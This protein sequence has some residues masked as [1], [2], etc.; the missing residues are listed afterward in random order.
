MVAHAVRQLASDHTPI[1]RIAAQLEAEQEARALTGDD[2]ECTGR[3]VTELVE[4]G[5]NA[6]LPDRF[7]Y[8]MRA[9]QGEYSPPEGT[10]D[11]ELE[12]ARSAVLRARRR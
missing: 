3:V 2:C 6:A 8:A 12:R 10:L 5:T 11:T 7:L 1:A 4:T 9:I